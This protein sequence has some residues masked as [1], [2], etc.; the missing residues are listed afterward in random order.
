MR[1]FPSLFSAR[2]AL[3]AP[4][5]CKDALP[6]A[7]TE[8]FRALRTNINFIVAENNAHSFV[9]SSAVPEEGSGATALNLAAMLAAD[10][11]RVLLVD[12][13]LRHPFVRDALHLPDNTP[14]LLAALQG[15]LSPAQAVATCSIENLFVLTPENTCENSAE[16]LDQP[17]MAQLLDDLK[18]Q[19]DLVLVS[20]PPASVLADAA[21]L[22]K[23]VD[24]ALLVVRSKFAPRE[25]ILLA[26]QRLEA[27]QIKLYGVVL[28]A[29]D[30]RKVRKSSPYAY[31]HRYNY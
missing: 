2:K 31:L 23:Y 6:T 8:S 21:I 20:A 4:L 16:L 22:G 15:K 3:F 1:L 5:P 12:G 11:K 30:S 28:T 17:S 29:F 19:Y 18:P 9:I 26:K 25:A 13:D 14:G 7:Y 27:V 24:G 10:H